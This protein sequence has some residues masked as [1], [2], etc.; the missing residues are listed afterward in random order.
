MLR[1][2][3]PIPRTLPAGPML[4]TGGPAGQGRTARRPM[5]RTGQS[6]GARRWPVGRSPGSPKAGAYSCDLPCGAQDAAR[7][8]CST[9]ASEPGKN[10]VVRPESSHSTR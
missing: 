8:R 9:V 1:A 6:S 10:S 3:Q 7:P 4:A 2:A 5:P